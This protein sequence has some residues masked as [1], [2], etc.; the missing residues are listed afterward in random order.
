MT[1]EGIKALVVAK[2]AGQGSMVDIG[3]ALPAILDAII[4]LIPAE[5]T[6]YEL[7]VASDEVL[8]GVKVGE[9]LS[10][11]EEGVLSASGG[12]NAALIVKGT[13]SSGVFT[14]NE[15]QPTLQEAF[16][17]IAQGRDVIISDGANYFHWVFSNPDDGYM[18]FFID[19]EHE[20]TWGEVD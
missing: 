9:N 17:A 7:P 11:T 6:P 19:A 14:P 2:I 10:I 16:D 13:E 3:G 20:V 15:G 5:P 1:K 18:R 12:G 4:D 8:G